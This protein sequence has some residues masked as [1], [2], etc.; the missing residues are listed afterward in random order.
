M[1]DDP[2]LLSVR[3][4][5]KHYPITEGVLRREVG[6]VRAVDGISFD[7]RAGET[8]GLVGESGCGKSTAA[9]TLL[10]L[11]EPTGGEVLFDGRDVGE[12]SPTEMKRFRRE[13]G[14]LF[15]DPSSSLDPRMTAGESVGEPLR[16]HGMA[17]RERRRRVVADLLERVGLS[18]DALD[19][20]PHELSGGQQQ[21]VAL[22]RALVVNPRLL[23]AD[24]PVSALDVSVQAEILDL[25]RSIQDD[26]GLATLFISH[27]LSVVR[28]VCDRVAV[29]Y[30]G[31][32]VELAPTDALFADP[33]H[34]YTRALLASIPRLDPR[35]RGRAAELSGDVPDP[36]DPPAGCRFHTRCPEVIPPD[37][38]DLDRARWRSV[39]DLRVRLDREG[40]DADAVRRG[41]VAAGGADSVAAVTDA[42][43]AAAI[44]EE[45]DLPAPLDD[46]D[47]EAAVAA[48]LDA[49]LAGDERAAVA[50]LSATFETPCATDEPPRLSTAP[51]R[52]VT[53]HRHDPTVAASTSPDGPDAPDGPGGSDAPDAPGP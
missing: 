42:Q 44:R 24:E 27:D 8:L 40:I 36:A 46:P 33:E 12:F 38:I 35:R 43:A 4:L 28:E 51:A 16:I 34:P 2:P 52:E 53:C 37:G 5:T 1:T 22:A 6:R 39:H 25:L 11:S 13:T 47:A 21:R 48:A 3:D 19:R 29:M 15:Q 17:D 26:L 23:V 45:F 30:L 41:V 50:R 14:M 7:L 20:Y 49:L 10:R 9:A 31:R 18:A 32:I